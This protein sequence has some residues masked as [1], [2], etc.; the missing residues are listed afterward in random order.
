M[1]ETESWVGGW[2]VGADAY[3]AILEKRLPH[4]SGES[5]VGITRRVRRYDGVIDESGE[6][7]THRRQVTAVGQPCTTGQTALAAAHTLHTS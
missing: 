4:V 2:G 5:F 6:V 7:R 3:R 1:D